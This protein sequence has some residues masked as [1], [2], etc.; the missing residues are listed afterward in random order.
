VKV[1]VDVGVKEGVREMDGELVS[2]AEAV[3]VEVPFRPGDM[4]AT[5]A[6]RQ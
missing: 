2:D 4:L 3:G 6:P 5:I 1:E